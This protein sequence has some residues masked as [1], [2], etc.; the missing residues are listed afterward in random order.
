MI[1]QSL[2]AENVAIAQKLLSLSAEFYEARDLRWF[3]T[4]IHGLITESINN[5]IAAFQRPNALLR[6]NAHF[7]TAY[8]RALLETPAAP[9]AAA[10]IACVVADVAP[11][12]RVQMFKTEMCGASMA[13]V[14]IA[15]DIADAIDRIGCIPP[16]DYGNIL[17][18]LDD[19]FADGLKK[20]RGE[21]IGDFESKALKA[22]PLVRV[23]RK[24]VYEQK[25]NAIVP[26]VQD[27][28]GNAR[29][30]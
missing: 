1:S 29:P 27:E 26:G 24:V 10:F 16:Q 4:L 2:L 11:D 13:S 20:L 9:W 14:H 25:C 22:F 7:A 18:F 19:A 17:R 5:N 3:F 6:F 8:I 15:V 12:E 23:L 21:L 28:F 30:K